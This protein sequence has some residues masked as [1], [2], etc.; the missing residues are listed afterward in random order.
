M[1]GRA[2][3]APP[4]LASVAADCMFERPG[5]GDRA[6]LVVLDLGDG[7]PEQRA[8]ELDA[9]A[10][11]A[12]ATVVGVITGRRKRPDAA[13]FAG[14]GKVEEIDA[15]RGATG[16]DLVIFDHVL[17]GA[18]Q[19]NLERMLECRVV[20]R[21]SLIL[22]IFALRARSAEGK[23]QVELAQVKHQMTRLVGGWTHLER[24]KGGIGLR[25]PG[26]T[27]LETDRRLLGIRERNLN[28]RL[29][30][31]ARQRATQ[32]RTRKRAAVR[33]VA[34]VGYTNA[35]KSTLFNRLTGAT[36][37]AADQ[38]FA[39]LDTTL[40]RLR[41]P[42]AQAIVLSDTVGFVRELPHDLVAAFRATL[43]EAA[44]ADLLLH[45]IDASHANRDEQID[46]VEAVLAEI[47]AD[48]VPQVRV[49]NKIDASGLPAGVERDDSGILRA[50]RLSALT[51]EGCAELR[52]GLVERF[53]ASAAQSSASAAL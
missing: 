42:G 9:L 12:G 36:A 48:A 27:Q 19:R 23:L 39:T 8:A 6:L 7:S 53:P 45:V 41:L 24:Q 40:R 10:V 15:A 21:T 46:A 38:L 1:A 26:E 13:L 4:S 52:A 47:G 11:S 29:R 33:T 32:S 28:E 31:V 37:Y 18:Q 20:D 49:Y 50:V 16:A 51:G 2:L 22:D 25:G 3:R 35:G 30:H 43:A 34:L 5:G 44:D 14:K 17:T